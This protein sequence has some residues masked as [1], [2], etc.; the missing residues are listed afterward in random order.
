MWADLL[1]DR[2]PAKIFRWKTPSSSLGPSCALW[3]DWQIPLKE[4]IWM[5]QQ[6]ECKFI[7]MRFSPKK[8]W[9]CTKP[10]RACDL[11]KYIRF[12]MGRR[13]FQIRADSIGEPWVPRLFSLP[14][15]KDAHM[16]R[17]WEMKFLHDDRAQHTVL[18]Y[19]SPNRPIN[20]DSVRVR[21][22]WMRGELLP[23]V[24]GGT[25]SGMGPRQSMVTRPRVPPL[26]LILIARP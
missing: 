25:E 16:W 10:L 8:L 4:I 9:G 20:P 17:S 14:P 18:N 24:T 1:K 15:A 6:C 13:V 21:F 23:E 22:P 5:E 7:C 19:Y 2:L 11:K 3:L 26:R 12:T